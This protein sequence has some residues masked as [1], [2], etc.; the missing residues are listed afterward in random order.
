LST[1][2]PPRLARAL[3]RSL[4]P[5]DIRE[6]IDGD[7]HEVYVARCA[8]SGA[9]AAAAWYWIE[10]LSFALRFTGHRLA[11]GCHALLAAAAAPSALDLRLGVRMLGR[12]A[13]LALVGG[14]GMAV[15]VAL[16]AGSHAVVN[17]YFYP[18]L[19][20]HEGDRVVSLARFDTKQQMKDEQLLH[21]FLVWRRELRAVVDLGAF[22]DVQR[23]IIT[24]DAYSE[25]ISIAEMT[26]SGFRVARVAPLLGRPLIDDDERPGAQP[27]AVIGYDAWQSRFAGDPGIVGREIRLGRTTHTVVGVMPEGFAFPI[28]H[29]YWIPL[30]IDPSARVEPGTGPY[31]NVFGRLAPGATKQSAQA[32]LSVIGRRLA[33][34]GPAELA[35]IE[36]R[37]VPYTDIFANLE[38]QGSTSPTNMLRY[39]I[40]L[41]LV[42]VSMN[43]AVLMYA[44]TV[45]RTGEIAVRTALGA[46]RVRIVAQLFV[47]AFVLTGT[48]A[49][50]GLGMVHVA[51]GM[52]DSFLADIGGG[53]A[54][55]WIE[56]GVSTG[57]ML[58][59]LALAALAALIIG[60]LPGLRATGRQLR[61][62]MGSLGSGAKAK[63]GRTWTVLIVAQV[64]VAV[65]ILPMAMLK[66]GES[67][68]GAFRPAGFQAGEYLAAQFQ[69]EPDLGPTSGPNEDGPGAMQVMDSTRAIVNTLMSELAAEPGV[70]GATFTLSLP[71]YGSGGRGPDVEVE[72]AEGT[73]HRLRPAT[74][75]TGY[76]NLF[77]VRLLAGRTFNAADAALPDSLRPV[78]VNRSFVSEIL[79]TGDALG[80]RVRWR[81]YGDQVN[82]WHTIVGVIDDF[83]PGVRTP[84]EGST[85]MMYHLGMPGEWSFGL[86]TVRLR[87]HSPEAFAP[88]LLRIATSVNPMLQLPK[89]TP[90]S[91]LYR[92]YTRAGAQLAFVVLAV[93]GSVLLLSA[94]GIHA[95]M[96]F[97]VNQRRRE[98]GIRSALG[99]PT[100]SILA[101]VLGRAARQLAVGVVLGLAAAVALNGLSGGVMLDGAGLLLVP[102][103]A[104]F[105]LLVGLLAAGG[106]ARRGLR[107]QPTEALRAD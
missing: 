70:V 50:V 103:T 16:S 85:R 100:R 25:P 59:A 11:R 10:A 81:S 34:E 36:P 65:A 106:P 28:N 19:P 27:V 42:I 47:E 87:G 75:D 64:A 97:T 32:E 78:V 43:V 86:I 8:G 95:M 12:S 41:L 29:Q 24:G 62:T 101:G 21:D 20:L 68:Q 5:S 74:V 49:L 22:A 55:F 92:D 35:H 17:S 76:F 99:A 57:T 7:L 39:L 80:R 96:S 66:G 60:A 14:M 4:V 98:I 18:E 23:N 93:A 79:G 102:A 53:R 84:G 13:G 94:A 33:A 63:L 54:P 9:A 51:L 30:R 71:W 61:T 3:L 2:V 90:L 77:D 40:A 105:M 44:R 26:A 73:G 6:E 52:F 37:I 104:A 88:T 91:A 107:V 15:A 38:V 58:Y 89:I 67:I 56:F 48:A 72:G 82:P 31:L 46:T 69:V 1:S 45:T 83:P